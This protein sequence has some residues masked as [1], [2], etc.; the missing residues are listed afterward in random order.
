M[1]HLN[2]YATI[3]SAVDTLCSAMAEKGYPNYTP[4]ADTLWS[5]YSLVSTVNNGS[6]PYDLYDNSDSTDFCKGNR[7]QY[8]VKAE[9]T[10]ARKHRKANIQKKNPRKRV[11]VMWYDVN[12][13][14]KR[15]D[16]Y[17]KAV[18]SEKGKRKFRNSQAALF[19]YDEEINFIKAEAAEAEED[20]KE[21][22]RI[23]NMPEEEK[24]KKRAIL[25]DALARYT[26]SRGRMYD[27]TTE[28]GTFMFDSCWDESLY[29]FKKDEDGKEA[30]TS[31]YTIWD[32]SDGMYFDG[33][34]DKVIEDMVKII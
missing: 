18:S 9:K 19:D 34:Y 15:Y 6:V 32:Y 22:L 4:T 13:D 26:I 17:C 11:K 33:D 27:F 12:Y 24:A 5:V 16:K 8:G 31:V 10:K 3:N 1:N 14:E 21:Y 30:Y 25:K 28:R 20:Y 23:E 2:D 29:L 7:F